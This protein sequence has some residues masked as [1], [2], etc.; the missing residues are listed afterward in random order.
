MSLE[1]QFEFASNEVRSFT[2][3]SNGPSNSEKLNMYA[4]Y[5]QATVGDINI[6]QPWAVQVNARAKWDAWNEIKGMTKKTA[7]TR[8]CEY[9]LQLSHKYMN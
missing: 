1:E 2:E 4:L 3:G 7:M 6:S 9:F 5:K 8:Y